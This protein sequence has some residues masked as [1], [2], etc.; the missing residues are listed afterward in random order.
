MS[1]LVLLGTSALIILRLRKIAFPGAS[2][3][4]RFL[5]N[6]RL[7]YFLL[8]LFVVVG[9]WIS[10]LH[11]PGQQNTIYEQN[12][13]KGSI[14]IT[15][16]VVEPPDKREKTT[17]VK[18]QARQFQV[19]GSDSI[20][21]HEMVL[22]FLPA[23]SDL[24][25]GDMVTLRGDPVTPKDFEDFSYR[26][27]LAGQKIFSILYYPAIMDSQPGGMDAL[28][29]LYQFKEKSLSLL[30]KLFPMP[31]SALIK[32]ILLG[33]DSDIPDEVYSAFKKSGTTHLIAISGF[34][35]AIV[36]SL[37]V[38]LFGRVLGKWRGALASIG[39]IAVY[40]ILVG[41][42]PSV[43]RAAIMGSI[44]MIGVLIG[45]KNSGLNAAYFTA[46]VMLVLNPFLLKSISFQLSFAATLG[47][48]MYASFL[49]ERTVAWF[50][51][52]FPAG[53]SEKAASAFSE[54]VLYTLAAQVLTFPLLL[55][56][57]HNLPLATFI[58][59]PLVLPFQPLLMITSGL[60]LLTA[61]IFFP[62]GKILA[63]LSF[64]FSYITIHLVE[65]AAGTR[66]GNIQTFSISMGLAAG[67]VFIL[68]LLRA[69]PQVWKKIS[70]AIHLQ[71]ILILTSL[72]LVN[73]LLLNSFF[74][75]PDG[76]LVVQIQGGTNPGVILIQTPSGNKILLRAAESANHTLYFLDPLMPI[77]NRH[78]D[79]AIFTDDKK[80][81]QVITELTNQIQVDQI[82]IHSILDGDLVYENPSIQLNPG[83][84]LALDQDVILDYLNGSARLRYKDF[85]F[86]YV[87][88][89]SS[90][91]E[92]CSGNVMLFEASVPEEMSCSPQLLITR[93]ER[94]GS[95]LSIGSMQRVEIS[96]DGEKVWM[97]RY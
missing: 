75:L 72:V 36:S 68:S 43:V 66:L 14:T 83:D 51:K 95:N 57:F 31:E 96:T 24:Q 74:R 35:V 5:P 76:N 2:F 20:P 87:P 48:V 27:Y 86:L 29:Y 63:Y 12:Q 15:G 16:K 40:T 61:W 30:G 52:I 10:Q 37:V 34:N 77:I 64:P 84:Q 46:G 17:L 47:L 6:T 3:L 22:V 62:L 41:A 38:L 92:F 23:K 9:M 19:T 11:Q 49:H 70:G 81:G 1:G 55:Y 80:A 56:H 4:N 8:P 28:G 45:R 71:P 53:W 44:A 42:S 18:V 25:Y 13:P 60:S 32:G 21:T 33:D 90:A 58:A 73:F 65:W 79:A 82:Y 89:E 94:V 7:P 93:T 59:N 54:Y 39:M 91:S 85:S 78:L 69:A 97:E 88:A 67:W 26:E 50:V